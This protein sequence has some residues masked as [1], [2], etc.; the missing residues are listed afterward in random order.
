MEKELSKDGEPLHCDPKELW[1]M[2]GTTEWLLPYLV[3]RAALGRGASPPGPGRRL[4]QR[5]QL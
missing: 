2:R 4:G 1:S 3:R 5:G